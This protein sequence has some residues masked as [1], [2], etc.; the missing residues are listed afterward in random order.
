MRQTGDERTRPADSTNPRPPA[1]ALSPLPGKGAAKRHKDAATTESFRMD[2][3]HGAR[4]PRRPAVTIPQ[5]ARRGQNLR[6]TCP[7]G[8]ACRRAVAL[9]FMRSLGTFRLGPGPGCCCRRRAHVQPCCRTGTAFCVS[10][11]IGRDLRAGARHWLRDV[12]AAASTRSPVALV[13]FALAPFERG[14]AAARAGTAGLWR[15]RFRHA[16]RGGCPSRRRRGA[17]GGRCAGGGRRR[18]CVGQG[19]RR[20]RGRRASVFRGHSAAQPA[21]ARA[22]PLAGFGLAR[23]FAPASPPDPCPW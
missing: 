5:I 20:Q 11:R 6:R 18:R 19:G 14:A 2:A 17:G 4:L 8:V 10:P 12:T 16:G 22:S 21:A 23:G 9:C 1:A 3:A 7:N 15:A 13:P